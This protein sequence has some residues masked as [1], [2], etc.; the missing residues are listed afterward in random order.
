MPLAWQFGQR[1]A[2]GLAARR[3]LVV[4]GFDGAV[5][6]YLAL[7]R[8]QLLPKAL[9]DLDG[10]GR[11]HV[12]GGADVLLHLVHLVRQDH[13]IRVFLA[14]DS[15]AFERVVQLGKGIGSGLA[16]KS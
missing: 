12:V 7:R 5:L 4:L 1:L 14:V 6:Q 10:V 8:R 9:A 11:V 16:L 2:G 15:L 3:S 13:R